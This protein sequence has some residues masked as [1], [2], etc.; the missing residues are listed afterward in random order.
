[1][2]VCRMDG[3]D[4]PIGMASPHWKGNG[5]DRYVPPAL[6]P[7]YQQALERGDLLSGM[8]TLALL[9][10][11]EETLLKRID[12]GELGS[13]WQG[14]R[15]QLTRFQQAARDPDL[16]RG[17]HTAQEALQEMERLV[18]VGT[19]DAEA[20][21]GLLT[22]WEQQRRTVETEMRRQEKARTLIPIEDV[23]WHIRRLMEINRESILEFEDLPARSA[24]KLLQVIADR[25]AG[26]LGDRGARRRPEESDGD[27]AV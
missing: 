20:W 4:S 18:T 26:V 5:R 17:K 19:R 24:R 10:G 25:Y 13:A 12:S 15:E 16:E 11:R 14:V 27:R 9:A 7:T 2:R 6:L 8:R 3:G 23:L 21:E 22:V 1:M